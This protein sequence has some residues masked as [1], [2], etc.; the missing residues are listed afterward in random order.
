MYY[1]T[2]AQIFDALPK[3]IQSQE[4]VDAI[5]AWHRQAVR[6]VVIDALEKSNALSGDE[7]LLDLLKIEHYKTAQE[8]AQALENVES[9]QS[10]LLELASQ[11]DQRLDEQKN[12]VFVQLGSREDVQ[13]LL[14]G[15]PINYLAAHVRG[16]VEREADLFQQIREILK[17]A[18][19]SRQGELTPEQKLQLQDAV[20]A[21]KAKREDMN[22]WRGMDPKKAV[23][24]TPEAT[25][26][27]SS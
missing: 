23:Q 27:P 10:E 22:Q 9:I 15:L 19:A 17:L 21:F 4:T 26:S 8:A 1:E 16:L 5:L 12:K 24:P 13:P 3:D 6:P 14:D 2:R 11:V 20:N 7:G 18:L 25:D